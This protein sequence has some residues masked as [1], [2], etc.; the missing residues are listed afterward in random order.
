MPG[1]TQQPLRPPRGWQDRHGVL[2]QI[3][4]STIGTGR[5]LS[6]DTEHPWLLSVFIGNGCFHLRTH[7]V[8]QGIVVIQLV[9][10]SPV[11]CRQGPTAGQGPR[12]ILCCC[13]WVKT[14]RF[15]R[16]ARK[17]PLA[18]CSD[19]FWQQL[20]L[21]HSIAQQAGNPGKQPEGLTWLAKSPC[22]GHRRRCTALPGLGREQREQRWA[23]LSQAGGSLACACWGWTYPFPL[24][25]GVRME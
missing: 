11:P 15:S 20:L 17:A 22:T 6:Q 19:G 23:C 14:S 18:R 21:L 2:L 1:I 4:D 5:C 16:G 12:G 9:C 7:R 8:A 25:A 3:P 24:A 13:S 10:P